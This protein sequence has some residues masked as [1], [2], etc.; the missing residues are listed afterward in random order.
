MKTFAVSDVARGKPYESLDARECVRSLLVKP[1][2]DMHCGPL[3]LVRY[4]A[5]ICESGS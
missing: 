3:G 4:A 5:R 2:E 1:A